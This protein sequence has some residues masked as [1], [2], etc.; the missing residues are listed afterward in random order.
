MA[1]SGLIMSAAAPDEASGFTARL[2]LLEKANLILPTKMQHME[3][4]FN[5]DRVVGEHGCDLGCDL[6]KDDLEEGQ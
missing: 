1:T 5:S 2:D 4:K 6:G 3:T